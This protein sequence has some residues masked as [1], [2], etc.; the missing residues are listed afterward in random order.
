MRLKKLLTP[1][2]AAFISMAVF[3]ANDIYFSKIGIEHGLSQLSVMSIY[4]DELGTL[5]FGT[6]EGVNR[7]NGNDIEVFLPYPNDTNS[8]NGSLIKSICGDENGHVYIHSQRGLNVYNLGTSTM[9]IIQRANVD[10]IAYGKK[11]LWIAE[12]NKLFSYINGEKKP[13]ISLTGEKATIKSIFQASDQRIFIGTVSSGVFVIDQKKK[14]RQITPAISQV[15]V[16]Y[17]DSKMNIWIGTWHDGLY[18][19]QKDGSIKQFLNKQ[20]PAGNFISS[21]FVR[22]I[23]E[24]R[25][26]FLWIGTK[27]GLDRLTV[28]TGAFKHYNSNEFNNRQLSNESIWSLCTDSQGT[29]WVGTYFGGVDYF[30]PDIDFYVFHD[31]QKGSLRNKPFPVI[32]EIVEDNHQNLFLCTEG[33]GL[34]LYNPATG[35]YRTFLA[36]DH[37]PESQSSVN[38]KTCYY[39]KSRQELWLGMH[40]GGLCKVELPGYRIKRYSI[41]KPEWPQS[42][43]VRSIIPYEGDLLIAT[44]NGLFRF[45]RKTEQFTLFSEKLHQNIQYF[46]DLKKDKQGCFWIAGNGL[47]YYNP[48]NGKF[49]TFVNHPADTT[50]LSNNDVVKILID[51]KDRVWVGTQNG[52]VNLY[53]PA[54]GSFI[55]Y[56]QEN[57]NLQNDYV[58][59][60]AISKSGYLII[61]TAKGF[62]MLDPE[63]GKIH[64]YG[65]NNG[66]LLNSLYNGGMC[67][68][69][70][71]EIFMAGMNGMVSFR[72]E[73][74]TIPQKR[75]NL[76][77]VNLWINNKPVKPFDN[78]HVLKTS[79]PYTRNI[80]LNYKQ[81]MITIEFATNNYIAA[82]RPLYRYKMSGFSEEWIDLPQGIMK[83]NF[84]NLKA[85]KYQLIVEAVSSNEGTVI[86]KTNLGIVVHPPF[87]NA[88]Y[89]YVIYI[90]LAMFIIW[91]YLIFTNSKLV[92]KTSLDFE[93]KEKAHLEEVNQSKLRFFT[94]ISHEFRTPL[95]LISGQMDLLLQT[96]NLKPKV[97]ERIRN[98]K[99]NTLNMQNLINELL[100]FRKTEQGFLNI[101][102]CQQDLI[103]FLQEIH[104]SFTEYASQKKI[105]FTFEHAEN[106][107]MLW[108]DPVQMQKV[109][110][111]LISNAFKFTPKGGYIKM[112]VEDLSDS[113][114]VHIIDNGLG[115]AANELEKIF[116][117]FYQAENSSQ[118]SNLSPGTGIG[119]A[120][121]KN[122]LN[123]HSGIIQVNSNPKEGS[124]FSVTLHKGTAHF[125]PE[126]ITEAEN[127]ETNCLKQMEELDEEFMKEVVESMSGNESEEYT[128]LIV[129]DNDELRLML[130]N[131]FEPIYTIYTATDGAEGLNKT[132]EYEPDIVLCDLMMPKM[133]GSEMC[134][135]IKNNFSTSHIPIVLLTAQTA[136]EYNIECLRLGADDYITKPFNVKTLIT[137]CNNL[138]NGRRLLQEKFSKQIDF[139][140][141]LIATNNLDRDFME[142]AQKIIES[143]LDDPGFNVPV[144]SN[145][146]GLGR[147]RLFKKIK[148]ITGQT[149]NDFINTVKMK[150]ATDLIINHP[151][152]NIKDITYMLGFNTSKYFTKCFKKQFGMTPSNFRR[153]ELGLDY[154]KEEQDN[155]EDT[156]ED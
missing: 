148:G 26:G 117:S 121:T 109:F 92:L 96:Q 122:I 30:N 104:L 113:V 150:K 37:A 12:K 75:F 94:N 105:D 55:R 136:I 65:M 33:N 14:I 87:Y 8:L 60:L 67:L 22:T 15:S 25:N 134:S 72:E 31:L 49:K 88:W 43:I 38:I 95:T 153:V 145:E 82:N 118:V 107:I 9:K 2:I 78:F 66:F 68:T 106:E 102:V 32:S 42:D 39:D 119:L 132:I 86:A 156:S 13:Y 11:N 16:I 84:M 97:Y 103:L 152:Y 91:R 17:E 127:T 93:K 110:Y 28:E 46:V 138:V 126:Q 146:M 149:P 79:L 85:G 29:I 62:S 140:T 147:T 141:R 64:N 90:L 24:D 6:R 45:N 61:T 125:K 71:G 69:R 19:V 51:T 120:L 139:S 114:T 144:F 40:L 59:N 100:E 99:R 108:F 53:N 47:S 137:R 23:C 74:L 56:N 1:W 128:M 131:I 34:I 58:S 77:L 54:K 115:I 112:V 135:K 35:T 4:Q 143:H 52:G 116:D 63:T 101:R 20:N 81:N 5:W 130:K 133:S 123:L 7:Y 151:E 44:Y 3:P 89:A 76:N 124:Q 10:A 18:K 48:K 36:G 80:S 111:N 155:I 21:N 50:S 83:L 70:N 57:H 41:V 73:N 142:K 154:E 129:E 27:N 98:V